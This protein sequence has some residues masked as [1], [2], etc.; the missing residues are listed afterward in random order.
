MSDKYLIESMEH[1][2]D[3]TI[4]WWKPNHCGYTIQVDKAGRYSLAE[5][6]AICERAG[7]HNE[8]MWKEADVMAGKAGLM[9]MTVNKR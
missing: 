3:D 1:T 8:R 7:P 9:C 6:T 5:A 4:V 2:H